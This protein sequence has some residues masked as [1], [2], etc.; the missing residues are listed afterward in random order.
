MNINLEGDKQSSWGQYKRNSGKEITIYKIKVGRQN[1]TSWGIL[2][3]IRTSNDGIAKC[4][5]S[6]TEQ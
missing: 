1:K 2:A 4:V 3:W 5:S 6:T